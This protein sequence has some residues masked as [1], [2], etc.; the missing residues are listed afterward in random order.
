MVAIRHGNDK[1]AAIAPANLEWL[2]QSGPMHGARSD[3]WSTGDCMT[4]SPAWS[5][6]TRRSKPFDHALSPLRSRCSL[7]P[8]LYTQRIHRHSRPAVYKIFNSTKFLAAR[9]KGEQI[10][11]IKLELGFA[12]SALYEEWSLS[13]RMGEKGHAPQQNLYPGTVTSLLRQKQLQN[14]CKTDRG[15]ICSGQHLPA[16]PSVDFH[17]YFNVQC[18]MPFC[19]LSQSKHKVK[20]CEDFPYFGTKCGFSWSTQSN[21]SPAVVWWGRGRGEEGSFAKVLRKI[22]P[23]RNS[24]RVARTDDILHRTCTHTRY[25]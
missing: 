20:I 7:S 1:R 10:R 15:S 8:R 3:Q 6:I 11:K 9:T 17:P 14:L 23:E 24:S 2:S 4:C 25:A 22:L 13:I 19:I 12:K 21:A 18:I 5:C 16:C